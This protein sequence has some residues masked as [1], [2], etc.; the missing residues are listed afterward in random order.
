[1]LLG[2]LAIGCL[3]AVGC[4]KNHYQIR[5]TPTDSGFDRTLTCWTV[6]SGD[7]P[8]SQALDAGELARIEE[9]YGS[10]PEPGDEGKNSFRGKFGVETPQDV[11][12]AG[13]LE[14]IA[15]P[16]GTVWSYT[17]RFRG[18]D[19]LEAELA[20]RR[21]AV[22][23]LAD[24]TLGWLRKQFGNEANFPRLERFVDRIVRHDLKNVAVHVWV[25]EN[26]GT[27]ESVQGGFVERLWLFGRERDYLTLH[28]VAA[29]LRTLKTTD[30][31]PI[32]EILARLVAR[33][34]EI[35]PAS[36][37]LAIFRDQDRLAASWNEHVRGSEYFLQYVR[38][39]Y[40][41]L[42][43]EPAEVPELVSNLVRE[44]EKRRAERSGD[45]YDEKT[46]ILA[47]ADRPSP[48][49]AVGDLLSDAFIHF[50]M[51]RDDLLEVTLDAEVEP[52]STNV[53]W[54]EAEKTVTWKEQL[55][56]SV[57]LPIVCAATWAVPDEE[58]Q[59]RRFGRTLLRGEKLAEYAMWC[60]SLS[61]KEAEQWDK[62]L[63]GC[64][65]GESW[66]ETVKSFQFAEE[67]PARELL[68]DQVKRLLIEVEVQEK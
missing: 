58:E 39:K 63:A 12:G 6:V 14:R 32:L 55:G 23:T 30:P 15:T 62:V 52:I 37:T 17:E 67:T 26:S 9:S 1:M 28:D 7:P 10:K 65:A 3:V 29:I 54:N 44:M 18:S 57:G 13:T 56:G 42:Q 4:S 50:E 41:D 5:I 48:A 40:G 34:L 49:E 64:N 25:Q 2:F 60:E 33:E 46:P 66:T 45:D 19:D 47:N 8:H 61:E 38:N 31:T 21:E 22:D 68:A 11:G 43:P 16:L 51:A 35:D 36:D 27:E 24:L 20:K 53:T 59:K